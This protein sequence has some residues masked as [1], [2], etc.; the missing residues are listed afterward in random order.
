MLG[1]KV[2]K[3]LLADTWG[4]GGGRTIQLGT[5]FKAMLITILKNSEDI[6]NESTMY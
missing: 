4:G 5:V 2:P 6:Y 1:F 3:D